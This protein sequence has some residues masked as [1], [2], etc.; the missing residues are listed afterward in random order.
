VRP[1][2]EPSID[3][4]Y[5]LVFGAS[6]LHKNRHFALEVWMDLRR[7]G[8]TGQIVLAGPTPPFGSSEA[9]EASLLS[10]HADLRKDA[11]RLASVTEGEKSWLYRHAAL[12][13]YPSLVE[14][15]GLVPF[16]AALH[17]TPVL[18]TRKGSLGEVLPPQIPV[19]ERFDISAAADTAWQLLHDPEAAAHLVEQLQAGA[20][21]HRWSQTAD[22]L[23]KL[24]HRVME[25]PRSRVIAVAGEGGL[26]AMRAQPAPR[27]RVAANAVERMVQSVNSHR[28][29]RRVLAPPGSR[30]H[31]IASRAVSSARAYLR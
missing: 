13:L 12:V 14:G 31:G 15:F 5:L 20:S 30:R 22:A 1:T 6:Y 24:F 25:A 17:G 8:W 2:T 4:G 18:A 21:R 11:I 7:R 27:S 16:E 10:L 9:I 3:S 19:I 26:T 23:I 28:T 29:V